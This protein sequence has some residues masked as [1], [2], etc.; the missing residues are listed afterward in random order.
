[1]SIADL[2]SAKSSAGQQSL[3]GSV[4][5]CSQPSRC[6]WYLDAIC[7]V[8]LWWHELGILMLS[9]TVGIF[10][11]FLYHGMARAVDL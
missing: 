3:F 2:W 10:V 5:S 7:H 6:E 1:M 8:M 11:A 4:T 9:E